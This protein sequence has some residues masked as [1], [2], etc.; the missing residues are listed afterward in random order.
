MNYLDKFQ[1][2]TGYDIRSF[3]QSYVDFVN[4]Y[5]SSIVDY[6]QGGDM[7]GEAF[8]AMNNILKEISIIE[9][10]FKLHETTLD[11]I[12]MWDILDMFSE[13]QTKML[14]IR[15]SDRWMR[16]ARLNRTNTLQMKRQLRMGESFE[17]V[18]QDIED[19]NPDDDW[20]NIVTPQ[21]IT[22]EQY[23]DREGSNN[24]YVNL[25]TTGNNN[26]ETLV[27]TLVEDNILG[28]DFSTSFDFVDN[29][30]EVVQ[31]DESL[32]QALDIILK[33]VAGCVPEYK[34]YGL[35]ENYIG[36][37]INAIQYPAIFKSLMNMFQRDG[38]WK[39]CELLEVTRQEDAVFLT[40]KATAITNQSYVTNVPITK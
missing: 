15:N 30:I 4:N 12:S 22:E 23:E 3:F 9:P 19:E 35:P 31:H 25:K 38:R 27:D 6:Y 10:L 26:I 24:F 21:Y 28:K 7:N 17:V 13:I 1:Q 14:T 18:S 16:S 11:D 5:Y 40:I 39:S 29:D 2:V 37:T 33:S 32:E 8:Q 34:D 20:V 36:T